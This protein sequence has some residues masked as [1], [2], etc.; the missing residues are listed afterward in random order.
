MST[1]KTARSG[2]GTGKSFRLQAYG[3][4]KLQEKWREDLSLLTPAA[5]GRDS[6]GGPWSQSGLPGLIALMA[7]NRSYEALRQQRI[8]EKREMVKLQTGA[9]RTKHLV[10]LP[11]LQKKKMVS[12]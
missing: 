4:W 8:R 3:L 5:G 2:T 10:R 9:N 7:T 1:T 12:W 6:A 11:A